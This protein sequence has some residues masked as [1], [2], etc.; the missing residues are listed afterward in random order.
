MDIPSNISGSVIV[1]KVPARGTFLLISNI[2]FRFLSVEH[3]HYK[4]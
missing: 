3:K 4:R 1:E 2:Y